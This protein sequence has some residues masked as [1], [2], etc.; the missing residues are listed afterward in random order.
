MPKGDLMVTLRVWLGPKS[1]APSQ[2][3]SP[4][5][6]TL[7]DLFQNC[8]SKLACMC[9]AHLFIDDGRYHEQVSLT[10]VHNRSHFVVC[11]WYVDLGWTSA[12]RNRKKS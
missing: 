5:L 7:G 8:L 12:V 9:A 10:H 6:R 2:N 11:M 1:V 3:F 4:R